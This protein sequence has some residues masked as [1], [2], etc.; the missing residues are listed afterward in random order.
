MAAPIKTCVLGVGLAGLTFHVPFVLALPDLFKL[1]AVLERK[2]AGPGG[3]LQERFGADVAKDVKI[4]NTLDA[5]L[6]DREIELAI[7]GTPNETHYDFAKKVLEAGKHVLV[8]KPIT[9]N[10]AEA[11]ELGKLAQSKNLVFYPYQNRRWDSDFLAL[12]SLLS[13]PADD[14]QSLGNLFEF[15]SRFDRFRDALKGT[16][17]DLPLPGAGQTYDLG[18]HLID[19]ALVLFGRPAKVTAHIENLRGLGNKEVDDRFTIF[20]HYPSLP[21]K[22]SASVT[23]TSFTAILRGTTLSVRSPQPRYVVRGTGGTFTK[24]GVDPQE[25]QL[26]AIKSP[27]E[28][29]DPQNTAYGKEPETLWGTVENLRNGQVVKSVWPSTEKG[30]YAGLFK[31]VAAS[32]REGKNPAVKWTESA[33]VIEIIELAHQSTKEGR[34]LVVPTRA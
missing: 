13:L 28:I 34:T 15:E 33:D 20:L 32:I 9:A 17:K 25:D 10:Y 16:W 23:P 4:Y 5:V 27:A 22:T 26:R 6:A 3:K 2:P 31:D 30:D 11:V 18:A 21:P 29:V 14:P 24:F 12:R 1:H 7:V 19:Q 8:D